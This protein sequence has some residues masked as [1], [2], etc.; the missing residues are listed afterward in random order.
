MLLGVGGKMAGAE[1]AEIVINK[2]GIWLYNGQPIVNKAIYLFFNQNLEYSSAGG[3]QVRVGAEV[4]PVAVE[5]TPFVVTDVVLVSGPEQGESFFKIQLNDETEEALDLKS[6]SVGKDNVLYC[7]VKNGRF[8]ARFLRPSYY[9]L[10]EHMLQEGE[11][12]FYI[13]LNGRKFFLEPFRFTAEH[14][15]VPPDGTKARDS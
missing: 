15:V 10:T 4:S 12:R 2:E 5:D 8:S 13:P 6:L 11:G 14:A 9:R 7:A 3:Y 1:Q